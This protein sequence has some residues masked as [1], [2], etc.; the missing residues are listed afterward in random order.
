MTGSLPHRQLRNK[1]TGLHNEMSCS[2]PHRQL[3]NSFSA[4]DAGSPPF[5]AA[6]AA[7]K[8]WGKHKGTGLL[9]T[10]AQAAEK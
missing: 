10:A 9:F 5:T 8:G 4:F 2:L 7:E 1:W 3:R 6:Q